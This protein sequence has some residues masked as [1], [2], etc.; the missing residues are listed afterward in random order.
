MTKA[1]R[2]V[3]KAAMRC[4]GKNGYAFLYDRRDANFVSINK[5]AFIHLETAVYK[6]RACAAAERERKTGRGRAQRN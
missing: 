1:E 3:F 6:Y 5:A 4:V 2:R